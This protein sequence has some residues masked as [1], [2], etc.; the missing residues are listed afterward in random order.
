MKARIEFIDDIEDGKDIDNDKLMELLKKAP[1]RKIDGELFILQ[2][3][4]AYSIDEIK[5][6]T[7]GI[8]L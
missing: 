5:Q 1:K 8:R 4:T 3:D 2:G 7:R 6:K